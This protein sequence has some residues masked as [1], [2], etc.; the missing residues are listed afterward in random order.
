LATTGFILTAFV[1]AFYV[2][3]TRRKWGWLA[4]PGLY[5]AAIL[6]SSGDPQAVLVGFTSVMLI[7]AGCLYFRRR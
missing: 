2:A 6:F 4:V 7:I 5:A 3:R 1:A